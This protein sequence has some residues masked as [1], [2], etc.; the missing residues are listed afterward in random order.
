MKP[1][2]TLVTALLLAT[3]SAAQADESSDQQKQ[4]KARRT[5]NLYWIIENF[6][7]LEPAMDARD[8]R[9]WAINHARLVLGRDVGHA[10]GYFES[11]AP[12]A[13]DSDIYFIRFLRTLLDCRDEARLSDEAEARIVGFLKRWPQNALT[14]RAHW[15]PRFTENHDLMNLT[16]GLFAQVYR[17]SDI[18]D[19]EREIKKFIA[20]RMERGFVEWNSKCYQY[21]F[22]NPLII[23]VDHAPDLVLRRAAQDLLNIM[24]AERAVLSVNGFLGGPS[25][26]CRTADGNHSLTARKV[27]YLTD[28]RYD[29]FL[30]TIWLALGMGE[31]RF[32]FSSARV[33]GLEPAGVHIASG[34]EPRLKQDEGMF[35]ACSRF[36]PHPMIRALATEARTRK[37]LVYQGRRFIGWPSF[38]ELWQTQKWMP[39]AL[40]YYNT[41]HVSMGSVHSDGWIHQCRYDSVTFGADPSQALRVET[42]VPGAEPHKRRREARGRV[43]QHENW[44]L[45]QGTLFEDG[46]A[47]AER[48]GEWNVYQ[49]GQGLCAHLALG[50]DYHVLQVS[51]L[52][53]FA[54]REEF[55]AA[56][57]IPER[58]GETLNAV[59]TSGDRVSVDLTNMSIAIN[60]DPR[61]HPPKM[62][63]DSGTMKSVYG[64]GKIT[65]T[66]QSGSV[67]FDSAAFRP[68]PVG[69]PKLHAGMTRWGKPDSADFTTTVNHVRA[70]GGMS[71][72]HDTL[73]KEVSILLPVNDGGS[74]R[75]AVYAGGQLDAGPHAGSPAKL[76][77]DFGQTPEG[78]TGWNTLEHP[79]GI[80]VPANT[81]IWLTWKSSGG[82][83]EVA[84]FEE[85]SGPS[86]FQPDR[87]RWD[88]K[89][90]KLNPAQPWPQAWPANDG[91][92]FDSYEYACFLGLAINGSPK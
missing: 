14:S 66:T 79:R 82:N 16:L 52:D 40:Y 68:E 10:N 25:L 81:P 47:K 18:S 73:L 65:I 31:P 70:L 49:V 89:A 63:H 23:L 62:L 20:H 17:D 59:T 87:G 80:R 37:A 2:L 27:A 71:P 8:G 12:P 75:L 84:Y 77:F 22:S 67:T 15:P 11:F 29:G 6:D 57:T 83:V 60:G 33:P 88:S 74:V 21:H 86:N 39:G 43:V 5:E 53:M 51:D 56:L 69:L 35:F 41:P 90:I 85:R 54:S 55:V 13:G 76:L 78:Q 92:D 72:D 30:P 4:I 24:L 32:D 50:D 46:D 91:G 45:G 26:R 19:H 9:R 58:S 38:D 34:N 42:I 1:T 28:A 3:L 7:K 61:S 44:L 36:V 48:V 64:S